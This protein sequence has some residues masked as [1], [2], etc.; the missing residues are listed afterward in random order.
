MEDEK[1]NQ[2]KQTYQKS[3][4]DSQ[5]KRDLAEKEYSEIEINVQIQDEEREKHRKEKAAY[6]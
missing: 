4:G 3:I 1:E 5:E 2:A 6:Q